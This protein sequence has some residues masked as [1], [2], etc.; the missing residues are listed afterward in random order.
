M[1]KNL[2][3]LHPL[4]AEINL[5]NFAFNINEI[6][7]RVAPSQVIG[8]VKANAYG[9]GAVEISKTLLENGVTKLAVANIVEA[10]ELRESNIDCEILLLGISLDSTI[11][12]LLKYNIE[13]TISSYDFAFK[14]NKRA[15][16]L[17]KICNI[18]I[19][20]DTGMGRIGF[21]K[22]EESVT[23]ISSIC[24]M[25]NLNICSTFS[26]FS[27]ADYKDKTYSE[28]QLDIY[29]WFQDRL[30][31]LN[32]SLGEKNIANSAAIIDLPKTCFDNVR[33]GIIQ[34][35]YYP[36]EEVEKENL[37]LKPVLTWKTKIVHLKTLEEN[38][39]I[40]Y[41]KN[42][43]TKKQS[44]IAT[45]P[46]GY[47]DGYPRALSN[48]GYVIIHGKLAPIVGNVCMDQ[49]MV[50]VTDVDGVNLNDEVIILGRDK[51]VKFDADD[52]AKITNTI[53]YE[54]LCL[55]GRRTARVYIKNNKISTIVK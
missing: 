6:K 10:I 51:E 36:S 25:S 27:T 7:D 39:F 5:D 9:H 49:C 24:S 31:E 21:R 37:Q 33:P 46:V 16:E 28:Y 32:C 14:L 38:N 11:D 19:A 2:D 12:S 29:N 30:K 48:K 43:Q 50:D 52:F 23:E 13:P 54:P 53:N 55:I 42:F 45:I 8:V 17:N 41:G 15:K 35:G 44:I 40:G 1:N 22:S 47:G 3:L 18:H 4:W 34:Y 20:L 26:H